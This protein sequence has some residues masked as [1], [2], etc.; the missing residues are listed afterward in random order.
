MARS[1]GSAGSALFTWPSKFQVPIPLLPESTCNISRQSQC[2]TDLLATTVFIWDE[3][4]MISA[5]TFNVVDHLLK[6]LTGSTANVA[7]PLSSAPLK[8]H[9]CGH[10]SRSIPW[11]QICEHYT[12]LTITLSLI[13]CYRLV[14]VQSQWKMVLISSNSHK[15]YSYHQA[16]FRNSSN[17]S[18]QM[19][20]QKLH[21][22]FAKD[23][24]SHQE[25]TNATL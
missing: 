18:I 7:W 17:V 21:I 19:V 1:A 2:A 24:A 8:I 3:A 10:S 12:T 13:G 25:T 15:T 11:L 23:A 6:D 16:V 22:T 4:S 9:R 20:L 14:M 5:R